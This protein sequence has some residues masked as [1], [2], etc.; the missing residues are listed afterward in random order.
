MIGRWLRRA[1]TLLRRDGVKDEIQRELE[2]HI[3]M[4]AAERERRGAS[5]ADARRA[6]LRDFGGMA[7]VRESVHDA[8]GLT[9]WDS[10]AQDVRYTTRTLRRWPGYSAATILT[11]A[12]GIGA[13]TAVFSVLHAAMLTP[14][15][16]PEPDRLVRISLERG[17]EFRYFP[18]AGLIDLRTQSR[19]MDV[20][21]VYTYNE[22]G[23]DLM[24][25]GA[26]ERVPVTQVS[27]NYFQVL[28]VTPIAGR[29]FA[30]AEERRDA[31]V[32]VVSER[33]WRQY[34]GAD[35]SAVGR[36]L[37]LNGS[38]WHVIGV[39]PGA[40]QDPLQP[41]VE[42]WQ[43]ENLQP[44][45]VNDWD[46][47][48]LTAV[49]RLRPGASVAAAQAETE[50]LVARQAV[51]YG[52]ELVTSG[53][54]LPLQ[55]DLVGAAG[56]MLYALMAAV[57]LLLLLACVTVATLMLARAAAR[58]HEITL[59]AALGCARWRIV[60]QLLTESLV[61]SLAGGVAGLILARTVGGVLVAAASRGWRSELFR[62]SMRRVRIWRRHCAK[63]DGRVVRAGSKQGPGTFSWSGRWPWHSS[64]SLAPACW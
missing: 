41:Q 29:V 52:T 17:G 1:R 35:P 10:L 64:C 57:G 55:D 4:E 36:T 11:L 54:V 20:A 30:P 21:S 63:A 56:P 3:E 12:L 46:N 14:L 60:R 6:A 5:A 59:R 13:N 32:V 2:F 61:L 34:L 33:I 28:G 7:A 38:P 22:Q 44:G 62:P 16:Y 37:M 15:P 25:G 27:A 23:A 51:H 31:G 42:V 39:V 24:G 9:L 47:N 40:F 18:G 50:L 45:G 58:S 48:R 8:R 49:A 26:P 53:R 19:T 43:P